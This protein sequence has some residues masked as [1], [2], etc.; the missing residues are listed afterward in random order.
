MIG[1]GEK[2]PEINKDKNDLLNINTFGVLAEK[3]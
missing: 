2:V 1:T 3:D